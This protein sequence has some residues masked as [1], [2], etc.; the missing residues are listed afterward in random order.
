MV[1]DTNRIARIQL[2]QIIALGEFSAWRFCK[3]IRKNNNIHKLKTDS[4]RER[5][6]ERE[7]ATP[8]PVHVV[9]HKSIREREGQL[10]CMD[11]SKSGCGSEPRME[12]RGAKQCMMSIDI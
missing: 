9:I 6:R 3:D 7:R 12:K 5:E 11:V 2:I 8:I 1:S 10:A 4:Q